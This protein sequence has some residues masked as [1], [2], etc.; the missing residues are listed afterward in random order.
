MYPL[1]ADGIEVPPRKRG[2]GP[3][4]GVEEA[5]NAERPW[6]ERAA[7]RHQAKHAKPA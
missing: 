3:G 2:L 5:R 4:V 6:E 1:N 7:A